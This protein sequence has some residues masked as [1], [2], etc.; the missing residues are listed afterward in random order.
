MLFPTDDVRCN[1]GELVPLTRYGPRFKLERKLMNQVLS[2]SAINNWQPAVMKETLIL[3]QQMLETP[4]EYVAHIRRC[5]DLKRLQI[6]Y[7]CRWVQDGRFSGVQRHVRLSCFT[8][9]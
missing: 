7:S 9:S 5:A 4:D 3:L 6:F 8:G 1:M 2:T